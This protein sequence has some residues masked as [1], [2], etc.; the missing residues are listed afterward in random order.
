ME[1]NL[2]NTEVRDILRVAV[3]VVDSRRLQDHQPCLHL[4]VLL[5]HRIPDTHSTAYKEIFYMLEHTYN[6]VEDV[7]ED[8]YTLVDNRD[9]DIEVVSRN[10]KGNMSYKNLLHLYYSCHRK[11]SML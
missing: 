5:L 4:P 11:Q 10:R 7:H 8:E 2:H 3:A 6:T 1:D 9:L